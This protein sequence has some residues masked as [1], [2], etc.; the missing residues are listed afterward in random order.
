MNKKGLKKVIFLVFL[1]TVFFAI[2]G[3]IL[4]PKFIFKQ[5]EKKLEMAARRYFELNSSQ[6]PTGERVKT[7]YLQELYRKSFIEKDIFVP[8][9]QKT[10]SNTK[11]WVKVKKVK[12]SYKYYTYLDCE[13]LK[14]QIDHTGPEIKLNGK[15][16]MTIGLGEEYKELG[17]KSVTDDTDGKLKKEAV[18]IKGNVDTSQIGTYEITYSAIDSFGNKSNIKRTINIVQKLNSTVKKLLNG[19]QNFKGYPENNYIRLSNMDFRI[20]GLDNNNNVIIVSNEDIANVNFSK[21]NQW[22][23]YYYN[24]LNETTKKMIIKSKFCNMDISEENLSTTSCT[25]YTDERNIYIPS[26]IEINKAANGEQNFMKPDTMSWTANKKNNQEAYLTRNFFFGEE[27]TA[28]YLSYDIN[29]N[30]GVRPMF[31]INGKTLIKGGEGTKTN[32]YTFKDTKIA[33]AGTLLNERNT[34]EYFEDTGSI[35]RIIKT[36]EDGTTKAIVA[37]TLSKY[38]DDNAYSDKL[39]FFPDTM[40]DNYIYNP[41][42]KDSVAHFISNS[43][44]GYIDTSKLVIHEIEVPIY[45]KEIIYKEEIEIKKYNTVLSAPDMYEIFSAR[46]DIGNKTTKSYWLKNSSKEKKYVALITDIGV[47]YVGIINEYNPYGIRVVGYFKKDVT[48][49]N[50]EGTE[51]NPYKVK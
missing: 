36:E 29:D 42:K 33:K 39:T 8:Y 3:F 48:I 43:L 21:L 18:T 13:M 51:T 15:E 2:G 25:S 40:N 9:T 41:K 34:G 4:Y 44:E 45:K 12:G 30:Y 16:K 26:I 23:E 35:W 6:L 19:E 1:A 47:P 37:T 10:C 22:L 50:G 7:I 28:N 5:N 24:N 32:P 49:I 14:S 27:Y 11:S 31:T 20:Y 17:I 46:E 38:K